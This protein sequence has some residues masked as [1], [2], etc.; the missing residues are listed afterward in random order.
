MGN[1]LNRNL[2]FFSV[3][4]IIIADMIGT[5]IFTTSGLVMEQVSNPLLMIVLWVAGG[6]VAL[7]GALCYAELSTAMPYAGGEYLYLNR[8]F[9]PSLGF[10]SGWI[11]FIVGFSAPLAAVAIGMSEYMIQAFP[12]LSFP[13]SIMGLSS[14]LF[15][16]KAI[17]LAVILIFTLVHLQNVKTRTGTHNLFTILK[18]VMILLLVVTGF[19]LGAGSFSKF[20]PVD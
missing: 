20:T 8:L 9:H 5:G 13:G 2:G 16:K 7:S 4:A 1:T 14:A 17:A 18:I 6:V 19:V 3:S 11:S 10:L 15:V 12:S